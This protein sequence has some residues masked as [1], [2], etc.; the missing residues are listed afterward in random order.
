MDGA[1]LG[2][3]YGFSTGKSRASLRPVVEHGSQAAMRVKV[4]AGR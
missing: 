1:T 3:S 4:A 2:E